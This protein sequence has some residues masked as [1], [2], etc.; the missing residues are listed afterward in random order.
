M[1]ATEVESLIALAHREPEWETEKA[2][3]ALAKLRRHF[4][5]PLEVRERL[6]NVIFVE[7][8]CSYRIML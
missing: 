2:N 3:V 6:R 5:E 7:S 1:M 8:R 4:L